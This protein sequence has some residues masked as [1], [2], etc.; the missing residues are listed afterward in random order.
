MYQ[1]PQQPNVLPHQGFQQGVPPMS[2]N[3]QHQ[4]QP[5]QPVPNNFVQ[6]PIGGQQPYAPAQIPPPQHM[7]APIMNT[8][9]VPNQMVHTQNY[10]MA[11]APPGFGGVPNQPVP[12]PPVSSWQQQRQQQRPGG[13]ADIM[14]IAAKAAQALAASQ[15]ILQPNYRQPP[16]ILQ[17][18][19]QQQYPQ[20]QHQQQYPAQAQ[21]Q[22]SAPQA[23]QQLQY[24]AQQYQQQPTPPQQYQQQQV[25]AQQYPPPVRRGRTVAKMHELPIAVQFAVQVRLFV[26]LLHLLV[27]FLFAHSLFSMLFL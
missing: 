18:V 15:N 19:V 9:G 24:P 2:S 23:Q 10:A 22:Y 4:M 5:N 8:V 11:A 6:P 1:N 20:A 26:G 13:E 16:V 17:P 21:Q 14:G 3:I 12:N 27:L 25:P 7:A